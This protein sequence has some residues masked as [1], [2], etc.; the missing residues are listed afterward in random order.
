MKM[1][2]L[3]Q[4]FF[5]IKKYI[6]MPKTKSTHIFLV[7]LFYRMQTITTRKFSQWK[8]RC[9]VRQIE[10]YDISHDD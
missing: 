4:F 3:V 2:D 10:I 6:C 1:H 8:I 7:N 5:I 9:L